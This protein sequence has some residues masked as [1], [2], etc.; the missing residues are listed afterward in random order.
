MT[1]LEGY[2]LRQLYA[3]RISPKTEVFPTSRTRQ[4]PPGRPRRQQHSVLRRH[5]H[6]GQP[7]QPRGR[8]DDHDGRLQQPGRPTQPRKQRQRRHA[9][10]GQFHRRSPTGKIVLFCFCF[11][12]LLVSE[13]IS[14]RRENEIAISLSPSTFPL[15]SSFLL[16]GLGYHHCDYANPMQTFSLFSSISL[17]PL[18]LS[19]LASFPP[20]IR[21]LASRP[22]K[23]S[24]VAYLKIRRPSA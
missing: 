6:A 23:F 15:S 3:T 18:F 14:P 9:I 19:A 5:H 17:S 10:Q 2:L 22:M 16:A 7:H 1:F 24:F 12:F 8:D 11:H 20:H 13:I 4:R 21:L